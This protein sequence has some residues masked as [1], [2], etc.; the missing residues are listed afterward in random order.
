MYTV[1]IRLILLSHTGSS[2]DEAPTSQAEGTDFES[3]LGTILFAHILGHS[4]QMFSFWLSDDSKL[5]AGA[6]LIIIIM[7][8]PQ[9]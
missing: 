3:S 4:N 9:N 2:L 6:L 1:K 7:L 5:D 8:I